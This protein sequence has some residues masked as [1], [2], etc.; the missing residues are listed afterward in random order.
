[1][2]QKINPVGNKL[3]ILQLWDYKT[4]LYGRT[5][6]EYTKSIRIL[7]Y[8]LTYLERYLAKTNI[9][10]EEFQITKSVHQI[11]IK[12]Y[13]LDLNKSSAEKEYVTSLMNT[14]SYWLKNI[15]FKLTF[16]QRIS[17]EDSSSLL[18]IN[19]MRY[20]LSQKK[21]TP[22]K[23]VQS[24]YKVINNQRSR[25]KIVST[26]KGLQLVKLIGFKMEFSGCFDSSKTQMAK[27]LKFNFGSLSLTKLNNYVDYSKTTFFTKFGSCGIKLWLFYDFL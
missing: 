5:F 11:L 10:I 8:S 19:Y 15:P 16:C 17:I 18:L 27:T 13:L 21:T 23:I 12:V 25:I 9:L 24:I 22:K 4:Q 14:L 26:T 6:N 7:N 2:S 20:L 1:M 3:G